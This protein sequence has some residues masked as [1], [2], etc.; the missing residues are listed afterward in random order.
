MRMGAMAF[1]GGAD[2]QRQLVQASQERQAFQRQLYRKWNTG[3][4]Y[5]PHDLSSVEQK[6][7]KIARKTPASDAFDTLGINPISEYKV[8][9][10]CG[11]GRTTQLTRRR[12][13]P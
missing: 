13:S 7:W 3:D 9:A 6:K 12:T 8:G 1:E 11:E 2:R 10:A 5:G 4:V